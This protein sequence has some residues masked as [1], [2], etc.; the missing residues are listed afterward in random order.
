MK[1]LP[2][3]DKVWV[4]NVQE[5][6][7]WLVLPTRTIFWSVSAF[8]DLQNANTTASLPFVFMFLPSP[9]IPQLFISSLYNRSL[10]N[11]CFI[12]W[13]CQCHP[14]G[15]YCMVFSK[16]EPVFMSLKLCLEC[17]P[18]RWVLIF[19][20]FCCTCIKYCSLYCK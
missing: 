19:F 9:L 1:L 14:T 8:L 15:F 17:C 6:C 5:I 13:C 12:F 16:G 2:V 7:E 11:T 3:F 18:S 4:Q 20:T 10:D